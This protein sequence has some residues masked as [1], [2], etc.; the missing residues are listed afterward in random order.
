M[1]LT[2]KIS[3]SFSTRILSF[4]TAFGLSI[5]LSRN[6]GSE[7]YGT[8]RYILLLVSTSY[9]FSNI[10]F[11]ESTNQMLARGKIEKDQ[12]IVLNAIWSILLFLLITIAFL[13]FYYFDKINFV[14]NKII[15]Y[16]IVYLFLFL[17]NSSV[18]LIILGMHNINTYNFINMFKI[19]I[20][21]CCIGLQIIFSNITIEKIL[22][23]HIIVS[24]LYLLYALY[25]IKPSLSAILKTKSYSKRIIFDIFKR[26]IIIQISNLS[27]FLNYRLDMFLV[28]YFVGFTA[29]G[30][31]AISVQLVEK[32]WILPESIRN[33][34]FLEISGKRKDELFVCFTCR[35]TL[36]VL[37]LVSFTL[38]IY[39][40]KFIPLFYTNEYSYSILPF[41]LLLPGVLFFTLSKLLSSYFL[42]IDKVYINT[43][44]SIIALLLNVVI[45][46]FLIPKYGIN[47]AAVATS[48]SYT[49]GALIGVF[50]FIRESK[51]KLHDLLFIKI[52]DIK[53]IYS[54]IVFNNKNTD[55]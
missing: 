55:N 3:I 21:F 26:G 12:T 7:L 8:Y 9:I 37:F 38:G 27:T 4:L 43:I 51:C 41:V 40:N 32:L 5:L 50:F 36:A 47:G 34:L 16:M 6:L 35:F 48:I 15:L 45:N 49:S 20:I 22:L 28:K 2:R 11:F 33:I 25:A 42:G 52:N 39:A 44:A 13:S 18:S 53:L 46:L 54:K 30:H 23:T 10:G 19:L 24:A 14:N 17:N 29:L 31:Y 1:D